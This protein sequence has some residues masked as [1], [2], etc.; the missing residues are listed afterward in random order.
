MRHEVSNQGSRVKFRGALEGW[1]IF[2]LAWT[3]PNQLVE[4]LFETERGD[5][6]L[7]AFERQSG[8]II[9]LD[10]MAVDEGQFDVALAKLMREDDTI[11]TRLASVG[12]GEAPSIPPL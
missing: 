2:V 8:L 12:A 1:H 5:A 11:A 4:A 7:A 9:E 3:D 10:P 6:L